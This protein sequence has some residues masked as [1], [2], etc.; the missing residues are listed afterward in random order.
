M[1]THTCPNGRF[2]RPR[3]RAPQVIGR[4]ISHPAPPKASRAHG[5]V[6]AKDR[7]ILPSAELHRQAASSS[8]QTRLA[9]VNLQQAR[10]AFRRARHIA[11]EVLSGCLSCF[12]RVIAAGGVRRPY[13]DRVNVLSR[14]CWFLLVIINYH[15]LLAT[16]YTESSLHKSTFYDSAHRVISPQRQGPG[17]SVLTQ[18]A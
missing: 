8:T 14:S 5:D 11:D 17:P 18:I 16:S 3:G 4:L 12:A 7:A 2:K 6:L 15:I 9:E 1:S 13:I 10:Q